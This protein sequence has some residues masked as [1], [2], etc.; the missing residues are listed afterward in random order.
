MEKLIPLIT[1]ILLMICFFGHKVDAEDNDF[2]VYGVDVVN[3]DVNMTIEGDIT[4]D[5]NSVLKN[6]G[7]IELNNS[8]LAYVTLDSESNN[9]TGKGFLKFT[10]Y[11]DVV[12]TGV[13]PYL[14][15]VSVELNSGAIYCDDN[16]FIGGLLQLKNGIINLPEDGKLKIH[17]GNES[18]LSHY[19]NNSFV[20]GRLERATLAGASYEFPVGAGDD[21]HLLK[22]DNTAA[23]AAVDVFFDE[24]IYYDWMPYENEYSS[25]ILTDGGWRV[26]ATQGTEF[27]IGMSLK[28]LN[29]AE[30]DPSKIVA[31]SMAPSEFPAGRWQF[32]ARTTEVSGQ[33]ANLNEHVGSSIYT[34]AE[35]SDLIFSNLIVVG[36]GVDTKFVIDGIDRFVKRDMTIYNRWGQ[37]LYK[38]AN[39]NNEYNAADLPRGT[40]YFVFKY[41]DGG[42]NRTESSF[43]EVK[44]EN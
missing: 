22:I 14:N 16:L 42:I 6:N 29:D 10:G 7:V 41:D 28:N 18:S 15:N 3:T 19:N 32:H 25:H 27:R 23:E 34:L 5:E 44:Y 4:L 39:Y 9:L 38:S 24:N 37:V 2:F 1:I 21:L 17:S 13:N 30:M 36:K 8:Q 11:S 31:V 26:N 20:Q 40:Y 33:W 35:V 12:I 43:F